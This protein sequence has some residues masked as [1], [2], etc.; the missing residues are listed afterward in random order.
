MRGRCWVSDDLCILGDL[1]LPMIP[2]ESLGY[3]FYLNHL[4]HWFDSHSNRL[5]NKERNMMLSKVYV[6]RIESLAIHAR[7]CGNV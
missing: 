6:H 7:L 4:Y 5:L 2:V 3:S 1:L